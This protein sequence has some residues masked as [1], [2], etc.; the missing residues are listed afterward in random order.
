MSVRCNSSVFCSQF[1]FK[2][3]MRTITAVTKKVYELYT[4]HAN[5]WP[6]QKLSSSCLLSTWAADFKAWLN[7]KLHAMPSAVTTIWKVIKNLPPTT[8]TSL[9]WPDWCFR[10]YTWN[11]AVSN[12]PAT[13]FETSTTWWGVTSSRE[14]S[15]G[16][17]RMTQKWIRM[18]V[19]LM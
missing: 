5:R 18:S 13:S 1:T 2:T 7:G 19:K 15:H 11:N 6:G 14:T 9:T 4:V 16:T 10:T 12:I 17:L 8:S 3:H